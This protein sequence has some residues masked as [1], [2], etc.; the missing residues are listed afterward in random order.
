MASR[1]P[2]TC[3][4]AGIL[5]P[6]LLNF[7]G[8]GTP[9]GAGID[10]ARRDLTMVGVAI[11]RAGTPNTLSN[12]PIA[13]IKAVVLWSEPETTNRATSY[14]LDV[15]SIRNKEK[16]RI[17]ALRIRVPE[18]NRE[19]ADPFC[20]DF[21]GG[22]SAMYATVQ[23]HPRATVL[24][25]GLL[26][27]DILPGSIVEVEF[28]DGFSEAIVKNVLHRETN[29]MTPEEVSSRATW[30]GNSYG[31]GTPPKVNQAPARGS[32]PTGT[33]L[34]SILK[35]AETFDIEP[36]V[37]ET[38]RRV[39]AGSNAAA[40]RFEPHIFYKKRPNLVNKSTSPYEVTPDTGFGRI[41]YTPG[42]IYCPPKR[43][44]RCVSGVS[45]V[46]SETNRSAFA[47]AFAL[48]PLSAVLSTSFGYF[49]VVPTQAE[50]EKIT[51]LKG[52]AA[53]KAFYA[54]SRNNAEAMSF[55]LLG[56]WLSRSKSA[57]VASRSKDWLKFAKKYN[58]A[59]AEAQG[60]PE[61]FA[62]TYLS[63]THQNCNF[64]KT[65]DTEE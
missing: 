45:Y 58:G 22:A 64:T 13:T 60:Y 5:N 26:S 38:I 6:E 28:V 30:G 21:I 19:L 31:S 2:W 29:M 32:C 53:A 9:D 57:I 35:I 37:V 10:D 41:P 56:S 61:K 34:E 24:N 1:V 7:S 16:P 51:S 33:L 25:T 44:G 50:V 3:Y 27:T 59:S 42:R 54:K 39:E 18:I 20:P 48:D 62:S 15:N 12:A 23:L 17:Q 11:R 52:A 43:N 65:T 36:A 63:V 14:N 55:E 47:R 49:Q 4:H 8:T 40:I 46:A